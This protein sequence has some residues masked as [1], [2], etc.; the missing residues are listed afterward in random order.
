MK[1]ELEYLSKRID[2]TGEQL[3]LL[4]KLKRLAFS[5]FPNNSMEKTFLEIKASSELNAK[6]FGDLTES[7]IQLNTIQSQFNNAG[8]TEDRFTNLLGTLTEQ[9]SISIKSSSDLDLQRQTL[10]NRQSEL[11]RDNNQIEKRRLQIKTL[12]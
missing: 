5:L 9:I 6:T 4:N 3:V 7:L 11:S 2:E 10:L 8:L 12:V 1:D